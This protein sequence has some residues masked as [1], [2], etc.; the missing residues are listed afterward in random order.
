[1]IIGDTHIDEFGKALGFKMGDELNSINGK[2]LKLEAIKDV[3]SDYFETV[4]EGDN[5]EIEV[6]RPKRKSGKYKVKV[7]KAK[8]KKVK[9]TRKNQIT[10]KEDITA[11]QKQTLK[12]WLGL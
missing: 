11:K 12:A 3:M 1:M 5:V 9:I 6:Y 10:L 2:Q 8:A 4:K 7:L